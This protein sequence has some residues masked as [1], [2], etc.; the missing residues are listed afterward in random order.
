VGRSYTLYG[1]LVRRTTHYL[2]QYEHRS[3]PL[4][5]PAELFASPVG[6]FPP[7]MHMFR[8]DDEESGPSYVVGAKMFGDKDYYLRLLSDDQE[9]LES[10]VRFKSYCDSFELAT[11]AV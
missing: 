4:Y 10:W 11:H 6:E 3:F 1:L 5:V 9:A 8:Q 7:F 2:V